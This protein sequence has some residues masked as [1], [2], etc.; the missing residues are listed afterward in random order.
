[1]LL[2]GEDIRPERASGWRAALA[3]LGLD[4]GAPLSFQL[5]GAR[6]VPI[7]VPAPQTSGWSP[8]PAAVDGQDRR[9]F[10]SA[11]HHP[12]PPTVR[13]L[14]ALGRWIAVR[15]VPPGSGTLVLDGAIP[16]SL[17]A[18]LAPYGPLVERLRA[19]RAVEAAAS[20]L[21]DQ[22]VEAWARPG[23]ES[24]ISLP[25]LRFEPLPHQFHA[26]RTALVR[27]R[28]RAVLADEVGLGKTIEAGLVLSELYLRR[29][30]ERTLI[31]VPAGLVE[32][33]REELDRK[34]A[35]PCLAHG[36]PEWEAAADPWSSPVIV[37]SLA[38]ARREPL[39]ERVAAMPWDLLVVDE[40]HRLKN[41]RTASSR[42]VKSLQ[43]RHLLLLTATPV[44]NRLDDLFHLV[45]LVRP[46]HLGS[47][48]QFRRRHGSAL[49]GAP[50]RQL[51]ELQAALRE[52]MVRHRRSEVALTLPRRLAETLYVVPGEQEAELY[53]L[54]SA[55][56]REAAR[57]ASPAQ[58]LALRHLQRL[59]GS[60]PRALAA[61][62][63]RAGWDDLA[64]R[65]DA[66]PSIE[67]ART[68]LEVLRRDTGGGGAARAG[69]AGTAQEKVVVFTAFRETLSFLTEVAAAAGLPAALY[70]GGLSRS[71]K[72]AAIRRFE[73]EVPLLLT[74]E[75]A[76][77]GRN[78]QFC[79]A[80]VNYDLPW[81]PMQIEQRLGRIH[82]IGQD[83]DVLLTNLVNRGT[84]EERI[85]RVLEMKINL[86]ELVVGELDMILGRVEE[87][88][89]FESFVFTTYVESRDD[90]EFAARMESFGDGLARARQTYLAERGRVDRLVPG[91]GEA[92]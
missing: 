83:R 86:F 88:F 10:P 28:G 32:Q 89:D 13:A 81:N 80:M 90:E 29:L 48:A 87:D 50:V 14:R 82:R 65:A 27:L 8:P 55:R 41:P 57:G 2:A 38:A 31:L 60:S 46:G 73:H 59:A 43:A 66:V 1:V 85:L 9:P 15:P 26:A 71:A 3:L 23:F 63:A 42:L 56:V 79:H 75:A 53:A 33:W 7:G 54:V 64:R 21:V 37:L 25:R 22:A 16:P 30:A 45:N 36:S 84:V 78:L 70:H 39:R 61:S 72:D 4:P 51:A 35:L 44:E 11:A 52:V 5:G 91:E 49:G 17:P 69:R 77:E 76:G 12:S 20:G 18:D 34:F 40:A 92:R 74:T 19:G 24:F 67:K 47:P 68:L 58:A 62:L 6:P